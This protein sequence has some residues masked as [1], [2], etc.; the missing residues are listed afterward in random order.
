MIKVTFLCCW[1]ESTSALFHRY[2]LQ[3]PGSAGVWDNI[4][5]VD[6]VND[7]DYYIIMEDFYE[8]KKL[9][10]AKKIYIKREPPWIVRTS[11]GNK[12]SL[13]KFD[14]TNGYWCATWWVKKTYDELKILQNKTN[15]KKICCIN[16][17]AEVCAG[18]RKRIAFL[19]RISQIEGLDID[20]YGRGLQDKGL[21]DKYKG[22]CL[23]K[24]DIMSQYEY[25]I[26][27]E[28]GEMD[29]YFTE[30]LAD[31]FL[32]WSVPIYWGCTNMDSYF[33]K[34]S[35]RSIDI[36]ID[37]GDKILSMIEK[38]PDENSLLAVQKARDLILDKYNIWPSVARI[39]NEGKMI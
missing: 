24:Y 4:V 28:N 27:M 12:P 22:T 20:I 31:S 13:Y 19:K 34:D 8:K 11:F 35:Y 9:D 5:G 16:S 25:S 29:N 10:P 18:H 1:G 23:D 30:K 7:A 6:N 36:S 26:V 21:G 14:Y 15:K 32:S 39:V 17:G 3:S 37:S 33:P 2:K 38:S